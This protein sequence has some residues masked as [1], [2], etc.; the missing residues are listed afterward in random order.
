MDLITGIPPPTE[1]SYSKFTLF[2]SAIR[3]SL[4]PCFDIK[5]LLAVTTCFL[6]LRAKKTN[7]LAIPSEPPTNSTTT[8][9]SFCSYFL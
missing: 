8:S 2:F 4:S 3:A 1:A 6:F 5:D 9:I 7:F